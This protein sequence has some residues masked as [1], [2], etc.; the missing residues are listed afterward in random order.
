VMHALFFEPLD[1][2]EGIGG[3][4]TMEIFDA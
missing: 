2:S 4:S 1:A 3:T